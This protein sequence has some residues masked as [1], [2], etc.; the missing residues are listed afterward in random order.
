M[1]AGGSL[2]NHKPLLLQ[3]RQYGQNRSDCEFLRIGAKCRKII[4]KIICGE[5]LCGVPQ[6]VHDGA[7]QIAKA[8]H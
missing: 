4:T 1:R 3:S 8:G 2:A 5:W 6:Q 7:F